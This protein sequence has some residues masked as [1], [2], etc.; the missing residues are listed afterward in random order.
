MEL[1]AQVAQLIFGIVL[2]L[3][4][5]F[6]VA[7][8]T[9]GSRVEATAMAAASVVAALLVPP[10]LLLLA[11]LEFGIPL[12]QWWVVAGANLLV[13]ITAGAAVLSREGGKKS[14]TGI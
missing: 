12:N 8:L 5:G 14:V 13:L 11:N 9:L 6:A 10:G 2:F 1:L 4:S 3:A 7:R